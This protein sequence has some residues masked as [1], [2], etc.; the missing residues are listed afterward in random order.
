MQSRAALVL[1]LLVPALVAGCASKLSVSREKAGEKP[2]ETE[3]VAGLPFNVPEVYVKSGTRT[4]S[5]KADDKEC[6]PVE[7]HET[8]LL[9]T[10]ARHYL[11]VEAMPFTKTGFVVRYNASG[12]LSEVTLNTEPA[13]A[14]EIK[15]LGLTP[16]GGIQ[17]DGAWYV[18]YV[19]PRESGGILWQLFESHR[20]AREVDRSTPDGGAVGLKRVDHV[21]LAVPD[22]DAQ[23]EWQKRVFGFEEISRWT[24]EAEG[25]DGCV[26]RIPGSQL[27]FEIIAPN[28]PNSF[29]Q[30][31]L[32]KRRAGMHHICCE[33]ESVEG[34]IEGL[35]RE[36][37]EAFGGIVESDWHRH[38]VL[39]PRDS[40][41]VLFQLF[42][43]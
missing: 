3:P 25:Y 5:S 24:N 31:F 40:G 4:A 21:S 42:E 32:D 30:A 36:G 27:Q 12:N 29:V 28:R 26:M 41:G 11:N 6:T 17:D 34:A 16:F 20:E 14:E 8:V 2:G 1:G 43:E 38:T 15:A 7:F 18:T 10:G 9:P 39:H 19:H 35:K 22:R 13:G 33:V 37:I 23:V